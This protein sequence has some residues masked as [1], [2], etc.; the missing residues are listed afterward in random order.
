MA[1]RHSDRS[2]SS[3]TEGEQAHRASSLATTQDISAIMSYRFARLSGA[4]HRMSAS[5][6]LTRRRTRSTPLR[7]PGEAGLGST[8][9][10]SDAMAQREGL[11]RVLFADTLALRLPEWG[12]LQRAAPEHVPTL[13]SRQIDLNYTSM[14]CRLAFPDGKHASESSC[15]VRLTSRTAIE[16]LHFQECQRRQ[17]PPSSISTARTTWLEIES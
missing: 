6:L 13:L 10:V 8:A 11:S 5:V 15:P 12:Y 7:R 9:L 17:T 16:N 4:K 3:G 2:S 14:I 1:I